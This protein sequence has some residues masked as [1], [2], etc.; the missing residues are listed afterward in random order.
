MGEMDKLHKNA[1]FLLKKEAC[2]VNVTYNLKKSIGLFVEI[3]K[4]KFGKA[5]EIKDL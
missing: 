3:M 2:R 4:A 1:E 5:L